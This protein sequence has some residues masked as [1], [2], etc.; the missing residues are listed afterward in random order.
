M[1]PSQ[2]SL[3]ARSTNSNLSPCSIVLVTTSAKTPFPSQHVKPLYLLC[4]VKLC[5]IKL[6]SIIV[7]L[8]P[9]FCR[10]SALPPCL[11]S[12]SKT[13][14][15]RPGNYNGCKWEGAQK[16]DAC[17]IFH[18]RSRRHRSSRQRRCWARELAWRAGEHLR[19]EPYP[20]QCAYRFFLYSWD[21]KSGEY[22]TVEPAQWPT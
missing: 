10:S 13:R 5:T 1:L 14:Y 19:L 4:N 3:S 8:C 2:R 9:G 20:P 12:N 21:Q 15:L 17:A 16:I 6:H 22:C 18:V 11:K 7:F